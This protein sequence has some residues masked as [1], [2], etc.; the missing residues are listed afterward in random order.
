[1]NISSN[2]S[3]LVSREVKMRGQRANQI[4]MTPHVYLGSGL[5]LCRGACCAAQ[6]GDDWQTGRKKQIVA[7]G[8]A[9]APAGCRA[10]AMTPL[11]GARAALA[12]TAAPRS[13]PCREQERAEILRFVEEAVAAG[14]EEPLPPHVICRDAQC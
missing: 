7:L 4:D 10:R 14:T 8:A 13:M 11:E 1:M 5:C 6:G 2:P 9:E 3:A 12:L